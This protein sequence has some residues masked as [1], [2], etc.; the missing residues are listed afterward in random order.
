MAGSD[1]KV[2]ITTTDPRALERE[3]QVR[4]DRL[5]ATLE[6]LH[7]RLQPS[8]IARRGLTSAQTSALGFVTDRRG[9]LRTERVAAV[10]AV[11]VGVGVVIVVRAVRRRR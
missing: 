10:A 7:D 3:V 11:V 9:G 2:E 1:G 6:E 5:A 8:E 4:R